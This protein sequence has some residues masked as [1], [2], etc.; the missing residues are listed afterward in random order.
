MGRLQMK[1][2]GLVLVP[3]IAVV[4]AAGPSE[5]SGEI[6][7]S[8]GLEVVTGKIHVKGGIYRLEFPD[9]AGP[10]VVSIAEPEA[11]KVL[12][13]VPR[14]KLYL[15]GE[16][17]GFLARMNDP[18]AT[19]A[20]MRPHYTSKDGG[21]EAI[22]GHACRKELLLQGDRHVVT[23]WTSKTL[24]FP[25]KVA[26]PQQK[27]WW[28]EVRKVREE[29]VPDELMAVP[30]GYQKAERE[31]IAERIQNDPEMK[32]KREA[33]EKQRP[34]TAKLRKF[35]RPGD[36]WRILFG[37]VTSVSIAVKYGDDVVWWA[38]PYRDGKPLSGIRGATVKGAGTAKMPADS[39]P[40][41][42]VIGAKKGQPSLTVE[43]V[44]K[45]PL[46][47]ATKETLYARPGANRDWTPT[48]GHRRLVVTFTATSAPIEGEL[49]VTRNGKRA[50]TPLKVEVGKSLTV[51]YADADGVTELGYT[52]HRGQGTIEIV[53]DM[54]P[55]AQ[56]KPF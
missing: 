30:A 55:P 46:V 47:L 5:F 34:R 51:D 12:V 2:F 26:I 36:E 10:T 29:A 43:L 44:G 21:E 41:M 52:V 54:R 45:A 6:V 15:E 17:S 4:A 14:Y 3:L 28:A 9:P 13:L 20:G 39:P 16:Y 50:E 40:D 24:G 23:V 38:V 48:P 18:F 27:G 42:V 49:H 11:D 56:Q 35:L 22:D 31:A 33:W 1:L 19:I 25:L 32:A 53:T 8:E 7:K 37:G